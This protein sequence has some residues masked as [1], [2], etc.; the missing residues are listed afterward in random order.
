K[1]AFLEV[2]GLDEFFHFYG[3]EDEDLFARMENAGYK[4][5]V[6]TAPFFCHNWHQSFA[7]SED[8]LITSNPRIKNIM[9]INQ[10]HFLR[11]RNRRIIK[12][13]RQSEMGKVIGKEQSA[14]LKKPTVKV[15]IYNILAQ[16]E[17]FL[18]EELP[19]YSE[20][21][22]KVEFVEDPY[23]HSLKYKIKKF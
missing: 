22:V 14:L 7:V 2:N 1:K 20:E 3:S 13:L 12:P 5:E 10:Q 15:K 21:I 11:N 23:F 4:R 18:R 19:S 8:R 16:V 6:N 17:H 9:R